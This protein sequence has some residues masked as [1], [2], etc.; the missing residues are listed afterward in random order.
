MVVK[1]VSIK[2][3]KSTEQNNENGDKRPLYIRLFV[4]DQIIINN[5]K[6]NLTELKYYT[7]PYL[8]KILN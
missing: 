2:N 4:F 3:W 8:E 7:I 5:Y 6:W 1:F